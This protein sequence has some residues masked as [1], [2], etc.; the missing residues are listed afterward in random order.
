MTSN[1]NLIR[2]LIVEDDVDLLNSIS[3]IMAMQP[4]IDVVGSCASTEEAMET[5]DWSKV[6]VMLVDLSLPGLSGVDLIASATF[7]NPRLY[8][9][10]HTVHDDRESLF[11][12]LRSGAVGY[13]IKGMPALETLEAVRAVSIGMPSFSPSVAKF[14]IDEFRSRNTTNPDEALS[15]REIDLLRLSAQGLI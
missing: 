1:L 4:D 11:A 13:V 6:D 2:L 15:S 8:S 9:L 14:L 12:A 5:T 7:Q 3:K 10:V